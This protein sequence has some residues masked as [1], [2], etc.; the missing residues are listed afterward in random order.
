MVLSLKL[1]PLDFKEEFQKMT[2]EQLLDYRFLS[3]FVFYRVG[4]SLDVKQL[5]I[6]EPKKLLCWNGIGL[7][8]YPE[9]FAKLLVFLYKNRNDINSYFEYGVAGGGSFFVIDS[10]LRAVNPNMGKTFG[11][12]LRSI[13]RHIELFN[14][15]RDKYPDVDFLEINST[16]FHPPGDYDFCF[17]DGGHNQVESDYARMKEHAKIIA[18]HDIKSHLAPKVGVLWDSISGTK[19][20]FLN[21]DN[22]FPVPIGIGVLIKE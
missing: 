9:E 17:I 1:N 19:M 6:E 18:F 4:L 14:E 8:Q 15:Y 16:D 21:T 7:R 2:S 11:I 20:E 13:S 22:R 3:D 12:D 10:F 5:H